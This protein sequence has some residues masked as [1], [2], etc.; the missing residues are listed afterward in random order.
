LGSGQ[1]S[2][3]GK[4][5]KTPL[6]CKLENLLKIMATFGII[7]ALSTLAVL[8]IRFGVSYLRGKANMKNSEALIALI[9]YISQAMELEVGI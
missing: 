9:I 5:E 3:E 8:M 6:E 4:S 7:S 2:Q 1:N